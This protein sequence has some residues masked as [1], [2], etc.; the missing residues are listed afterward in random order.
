MRERGYEL[1]PDLQRRLFS[2]TNEGPDVSDN[3][4]TN[5]ERHAPID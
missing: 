3:D 5:C 4:I 2:A 1:S